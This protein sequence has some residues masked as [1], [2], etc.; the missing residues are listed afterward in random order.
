MGLLSV[1]K[2]TLM[3]HNFEKSPVNSDITSIWSN[4]WKSNRYSLWT[5]WCIPVPSTPH[6]SEKN[7]RHCLCSDRELLSLWGWSILWQCANL[8]TSFC[9]GWLKTYLFYLMCIHVLPSSVCVCTRFVS[10][11]QEARRGCEVPWNW[12]YEW[13]WTTVWVLGVELWSSAR[14]VSTL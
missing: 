4:Y 3:K 1:Q 12:S 9:C 6:L 8:I 7:C 14:L 10:S 13:L 11:A 5:F 2:L